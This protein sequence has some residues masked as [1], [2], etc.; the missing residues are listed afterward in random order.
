MLAEGVPLNLL[1][2]VDE[3]GEGVIELHEPAEL[4]AD[5]VRHDLRGA[6]EGLKGLA[7]GRVLLFFRQHIDGSSSPMK[8]QVIHNLAKTTAETL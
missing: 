5:G 4:L 3:G 2:D 1:E 8:E 6:G 7:E